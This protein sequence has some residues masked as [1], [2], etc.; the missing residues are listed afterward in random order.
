MSTAYSL[1]SDL[2]NEVAPHGI[3][4]MSRA[5]E[6]A[7]RDRIGSLP[8]G[9]VTHDERRYPTTGKAMRAF[10]N[11]FFVRHF[12]QVQHSLLAWVA[13]RDL[14][15]LA[16]SERMSIADVGSGPS[17]ATI[18]IIDLVARARRILLASSHSI[19]KRPLVVTIVLNDPSRIC[20]DTGEQIVIGYCR[21]LSGQV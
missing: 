14:L 15:S 10:L 12:L 16:A 5:V 17:V 7:V 2:L 9:A 3:W 11:A 4:R 20:L 21:A 1:L 13:P 19:Q 18:A 8:G 6:E